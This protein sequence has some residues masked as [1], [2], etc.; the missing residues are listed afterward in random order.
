MVWLKRTDELFWNATVDEI[1]KGY[2]YDDFTEEYICLICGKSFTKGIIY[3]LSDILYDAQ[4]AIKLHINNEHG[5]VFEYLINMNKKYT[6]L[7]DIQKD[8][9]NFFYKGI[10][11]KEIIELQ[12]G[13]ST[14]TIRNH[15]FKLKEKEKQ[16][17]V[18]LAMME[19][20]EKK[21]DKGKPETEGM[22]FINIHKGATMVD[23]R[24]AITEKDRENVIK[25]YIKEDRLTVFPSKEKKKIIIL[26]YFMKKFE[27][28]R[29]YSEKEVNEIIKQLYDDY[30]TVRRYLIEYGFM[31]RNNDCSQYWVRI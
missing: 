11:D 19:L 17:K 25:N 22:E 27:L 6:G 29:S 10:S 21:K 1:V 2:K 28:N 23:D 14:S 26:Q 30:V 8:I 12:G 13:G 24:Y 15:R 3:P 5:S 20:L 9:L 31:E 18:F 7:T 16:A 4:K